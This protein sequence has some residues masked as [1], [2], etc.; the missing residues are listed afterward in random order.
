MRNY[1][2]Q[3]H[4]TLTRENLYNTSDTS[5]VPAFTDFHGQIIFSIIMMIVIGAC[6]IDLMITW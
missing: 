3:N 6:F 2:Y 5:G 1:I 4:V